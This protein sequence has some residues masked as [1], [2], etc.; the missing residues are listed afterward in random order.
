M[1]GVCK[2]GSTRHCPSPTPEF[3]SSICPQ[4]PLRPTGGQGGRW[5]DERADKKKTTPQ[6]RRERNL[7]VTKSTFSQPLYHSSVTIIQ[8]L[9]LSSPPS[10]LLPA[11][12]LLCSCR[13]LIEVWTAGGYYDTFAKRTHTHSHTQT[14]NSLCISYGDNQIFKMS[15]VHKTILLFSV[16]C[17]ATAALCVHVCVCVCVCVFGGDVRFNDCFHPLWKAASPQIRN[18]LNKSHN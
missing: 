14:P 12:S 3:S 11:L 17:Y 15:E 4:A 16:L 2:A 18:Q 5:I 13:G 10:A 8:S 6:R 9:L 1:F 7:P